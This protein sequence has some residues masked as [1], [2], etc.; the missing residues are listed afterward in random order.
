MLNTN[1]AEAAGFLHPKL[2]GYLLVFG[3]LPCGL[4]AIIRIQSAGRLRLA[5]TALATVFIGLGWIYLASGTW[6][7][8][9]ENA[10]KLGGM[11]MPWSYVVNVVRYQSAPLRSS[12]EYALLPPAIF[13]TNDKTVVVLVIGEAARAQNFSL[14]GYARPTNPSLTESG[15]VVLKNAIACSTYTTA[16]LRCIL[17]HTDTGSVFSERYEPLPSYLQRQGIDVVWRTT[18][19]GEPSIKVQS[20][21]RGRDLKQDCTGTGCDH[22]EVLL[23]GLSERIRSSKRHNVFVILHQRGSHGPS[24]Y[25]E[26]PRQFELF[27]PVCRSVALN[28]CSRDELRNA[29]DNTILYTD[30]FLGRVI[31]LL[32]NLMNTS[33]VFMYI[34]DHGESLGEHGLYLHGAPFSIA[35][36]EQKNV[37]FIVWMSSEFADRKG[38]TFT[39]LGQRDGHSQKNVFHSIMGAFDMRS[40]VYDARLDVFN[41]SSIAN[42]DE[43]AHA[44]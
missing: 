25:S 16:S 7:W 10:K 35:P 12:H 43:E 18:N 39:Q 6:L 21:Q 42:S 20:F 34:S 22:D 2:F 1:F 13:A 27:T 28:Q 44:R 30:H 23:T 8:I 5:V 40:D 38:I 32:N 15:V 26:Y 14:Y 17:S 36:D 33:A 3:L 31:H 37:P 29:Y 4:L 24:Y 11:V 9:D 19:W 41:D